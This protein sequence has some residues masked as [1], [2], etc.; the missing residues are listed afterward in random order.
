MPHLGN[1]SERCYYLPRP[2]PT[3]SELHKFAIFFIYFLHLKNVL[4]YIII[5]K[6]TL[7]HKCFLK[8]FS[9]QA[10]SCLSATEADSS[11]D[12]RQGAGTNTNTNTK[13][14]IKTNSK[15]ILIQII[16]KI[17]IQILIQYWYKHKHKYEELKLYMLRMSFNCQLADGKP[18]GPS[19]GP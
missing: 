16:M 13:A 11:F 18:T 3:I 12:V 4:I 14:N 5:S 19:H 6:D 8:T 15:K 2:H 17:L 10:H 1:N 9:L 7:A